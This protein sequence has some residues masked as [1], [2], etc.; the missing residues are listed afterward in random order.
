MYNL[1]LFLTQLNCSHTTTFSSHLPQTN[2]AYFLAQ[3]I[4]K[5][6]DYLISLKWKFLIERNCKIVKIKGR[7]AQ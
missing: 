1:S 4:N 3:K 7:Y 2:V 5:V 6:W